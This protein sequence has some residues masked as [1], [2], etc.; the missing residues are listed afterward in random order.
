[1]SGDSKNLFFLILAII[2]AVVVL[3]WA[4]RFA[5]SLLGLIIVVGLI[6]LGV[7]FVQNFLRSGR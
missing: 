5:A 4:L 1:M 2:G 6:I 7:V 3:G